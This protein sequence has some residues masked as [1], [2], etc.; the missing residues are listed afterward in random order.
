M[1]ANLSC[2]QLNLIK[3]KHFIYKIYEH[4]FI[5]FQINIDYVFKDRVTFPIMIAEMEKYTNY[6]IVIYPFEEHF[7]KIVVEKI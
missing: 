1:A 4:L 6:R 2:Y 5:K 7:F 3:L